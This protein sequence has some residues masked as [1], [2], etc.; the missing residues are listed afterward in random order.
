MYD[1]DMRPGLGAAI[2][3]L[4]IYL[5][6]FL[7][8]KLIISSKVD[9][10][11]LLYVLYV[12]VSFLWFLFSGMPV[13]VYLREFSNSIL[14][15]GFYFIAKSEAG[16][17]D[18][19]YFNSLKVIVI[20]FLIGFALHSYMPLFYLKYM[21]LIEAI[22]GKGMAFLRHYY[23]SIWGLTVTGSLGVIGLLIGFKQF[24]TKRGKVAHFSLFICAIGLIM[25]YRRSAIIVGLATIA[26][27][28]IFGLFKFKTINLK[29][30]LAEIFLSTIIIFWT[31]DNIPYY[32]EDLFERATTVSEAFD[33]RSSSW[34]EGIEAVS[35]IIAGDGLGTYGHKAF[36]YSNNTITDGNYFKIAAELGILGASLFIS[37]IIVSILKASRNLKILLIEVGIVIAL[38]L[39]AIGSNIFSFQQ[40]M[41]LFWFSIGR[42]NAAYKV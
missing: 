4:F 33:S 15:I 25:T 22:D 14:P 18:R 6:Y 32:F 37:I 34:F 12:G 13:S 3:M 8:N 19:F 31:V 5:S 36:L 29:F 9:A 7:K 17:T 41:P 2:V 28:H 27:V 35:N 11:V 24:S 10:M 40:L 1:N 20:S 16:S 26:I 39:Q 38:S 30:F 21:S 23:G 42:C